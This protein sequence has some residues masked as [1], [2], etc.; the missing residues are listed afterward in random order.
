MPFTNRSKNKHHGL[1][2][3]TV[4]EMII[5]LAAIAIVITI[6]VPGS[7]VL[8]AKYHLKSASGEIFTALQL[9]QAEAAARSST[10]VVCP[11]SNGQSCRKDGNWNLGWLVFSDGNGNG[12]PDEIERIRSFD[13]PKQDVQV[14]AMGAVKTRAAFT[15]TG[16]VAD[17][18]E[19]SGQFE[20]CLKESDSRPNLIKVAEDGWL[21]NAPARSGVCNPG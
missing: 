19:S 5:I 14:T 11:S 6:A 20:I 15:L 10:V 21:E 4:L 1:L 3:L 13:A 9:A 2:G 8:L 7:N 17:H 16:L 12:Q 18:D